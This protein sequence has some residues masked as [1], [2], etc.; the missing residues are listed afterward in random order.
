MRGDLRRA[1]YLLDV[2]GSPSLVTLESVGDPGL[3]PACTEELSTQRA[4]ACLK[5]A[6]PL[7]VQGRH[8]D[9]ILD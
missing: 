2:T 6:R 9:I 4:R 7:G 8:L 5:G 1:D 3:D